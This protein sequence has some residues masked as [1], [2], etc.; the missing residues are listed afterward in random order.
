MA[1][2]QRSYAHMAP[3]GRGTYSRAVRDGD[4]LYVSGIAAFMG[5]DNPAVPSDIASQTEM[6]F[7][8]LRGILEAEG[9]GFEDLVSTDE[10]AKAKPAEFLVEELR[11]RVASGPVEFNF[12]LQLAQPGDNVNSAVV[13]LPDDRRKVTV[14]K[15]IIRQIDASGGGACVNMMFNP[16]ALPKGVEPSFDPILLG[17]ATAYAVSLGRRLSEGAK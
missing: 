15:L 7:A 4:W 1:I 8:Y 16:V 3:P 2:V 11:T 9:G 14:G 5:A 6:V 13:P 17:R 10:E 12:N